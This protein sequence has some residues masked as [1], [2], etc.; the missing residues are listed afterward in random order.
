MRQVE[1]DLRRELDWVA[2]NHYNTDDPHTPIVI[3]GRD[4][5]GKEL[6]IDREYISNGFRNRA[7]ELATRELG[8]RLEH[9]IEQTLRR[10]INQARFTSLDGQ[11]ARV[12]HENILGGG[13]DDGHGYSVELGVP[14]E[15]VP[16]SM[17][18]HVVGRLNALV[19]MGLAAQGSHIRSY[20]LR[21]DWKERL[22][23]LGERG[24][25][26]KRLSQISRDA[27][28]QRIYNPDT[29]QGDVVGRL[30]A[31]GM[32]DELY[33]RYYAVI[34]DKA[35]TA[36][37]VHLPKHV[38]IG[39]LPEG[40]IVRVRSL[41]DPWRKLADDVIEEF[42]HENNGVYDRNAHAKSVSDDQ[43]VDRTTDRCGSERTRTAICNSSPRV[44]RPLECLSLCHLTYPKSAG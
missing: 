22:R 39:E 38:D 8:P 13:A 32:H 9:E 27:R 2:V 37:Y 25:I 16:L 6:R 19:E 17:D 12:S 14:G 20:A 7:R 18:R 34:D 3:R 21:N 31:K 33:D 30:T 40:S 44:Q 24:D 28:E 35:G 29:E 23:E 5:A 26:Y 41:A 42:A 11:I 36:Q 1:T 10:Q 43:R 15:H 4:L